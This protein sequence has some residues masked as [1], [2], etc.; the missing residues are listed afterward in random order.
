MDCAFNVFCF[1]HRLLMWQQWQQVD[2]P[3]PLPLHAMQGYVQ[4]TL[5]AVPGLLG[6]SKGD[7]AG[8]SVGGG[9]EGVLEVPGIHVH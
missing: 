8:G 6:D 1:R 9:R 2:T 3:S 5:G 7:T 4:P